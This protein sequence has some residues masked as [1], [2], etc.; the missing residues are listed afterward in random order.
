MANFDVLLSVLILLGV[1]FVVLLVS[2]FIRISPIIGFLVA[3]VALGPYGLQLIEETET[4]KLLAKMGLI[5]LLFDIGLHFSVKSV[6]TK[7]KDLLGVAPLQM[8]I[9]GAVFSILLKALF[10]MPAEVAIVCGFALALSST[11]VVVQLLADMKQSG[12]PVGDTAKT[13]L[14]FQDIA[15]I[16]LLILVDAIGQGEPLGPLVLETFLKGTAAFVAVMA[17]G[18]FILTPLMRVMIRF[19]DPEIFTVFGLLVVL[20][21]AMATGVLGLSLTLGAFLAG[22]VMGETPFRVLLQ[23]ELR[24]FRSLLLAFFFVTVGLLLNPLALLAE[25]QA[26]LGFVAVI[27]GLKLFVI[28]GLIMAFKRPLHQTLELTFLLSQGSEFAFVV[29]GVAA[30]QSGLG[31]DLASQLIAACAISMMVTP[32]FM[33]FARRWSLHICAKLED[34]ISNCPTDLE[35]PV[36]RSPVFIVG[37]NQVGYTLARAFAFHKIPYIAI[38]WDR[39]RFLEAT[40][41]GYTVTYGQPSD[42]R[43]WDTLGVSRSRAI[44]IAIQRLEISEQLTPIMKRLYPSLLRFVAVG[45]SVDAAK[46]AD[47]GL[48]PF[49]DRGVPPGLEM[50]CAVLREI[51]AEEEDILEWIDEERVNLLDSSSQNSLVDY[52]EEDLVTA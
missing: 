34:K 37:M 33:I 8:L 42:L 24:P 14:I 4:T 48:I 25:A 1:G 41:A 15:A 30:V 40:A 10:P 22:M 43:F 9:C 3:G 45:D 31:P 49:P 46:Y 26:I 19:E 35:N 16:F 51:G 29:F 6:W 20:A 50:A 52:N 47:L 17:I 11:A 5:F 18:H 7:R 13:I 36:H 44:C 32:I 21:L 2:R 27:I 28:G 23:T 38:D 12:S 39:R